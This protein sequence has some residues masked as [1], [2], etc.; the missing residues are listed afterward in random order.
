M[1]KEAFKNAK[2]A[3]KSREQVAPDF[4][5]SK[6]QP[7]QRFDY[8]ASE[9]DERLPD[10]NTELTIK[11]LDALGTAMVADSE[12]DLAEGDADFP[13]VYTYWGQFI[14]HDISKNTDS[15]Q[16]HGDGQAT[17]FDIRPDDFKP[18]KTSEVRDSLLNIRTRHLDLD[19]VYG[20]LDSAESDALYQGADPARHCHLGKKGEF[21]LGLAKDVPG[22]I[23]GPDPQDLCRDL[24]REAP[25]QPSLQ[26]QPAIIAEQRNDENLIVAQFHTAFLRFHNRALAEL[27]DFKRAQK[28]TR[29]HY[30]WLVLHDFLRTVAKPQVVEAVLDGDTRFEFDGGYMPLEFS[31][32][33][34]RFGHSMVRSSYD[35]NHSFGRGAGQL[36]RATF[37]LMFLF[38]GHGG[39]TPLDSDGRL[40]SNWIADWSRLA[41]RGGKFGDGLPE[42]FSRKIDTRLSDPLG[43]LANEANEEAD[44]DGSPFNA[45]LRALM[46]HLARRNLR[47][48]YLLN[49][50][51]G[52]AM[53]KRAGIQELSAEQ[54]LSD[55]MGERPDLSAALQAEDGLLLKYTPLWFYILKEAEVLE[56]GNR[57]G[58]L[59]SRLVVE[60]IVGLLRN[61]EQSVLS[62]NWTPEQSEL[63]T[64]A[65]LTTIDAFLQYSGELEHR[66]EPQSAAMA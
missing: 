50:P 49:I 41:H 63:E 8:L 6:G 48:G 51:T 47:R 42:R 1:E 15:N 3:H 66:P 59:G 53:A 62:L 39:D 36:D 28:Q 33:A 52:Q 57:L 34:Y 4:Y 16:F 10:D 18:V 11:L 38:T 45:D 21:L 24:P 64:G 65:D 32:A 5:S 58:P 56:S 61:S 54:L 9:H 31:T 55:A 37:D 43:Q 20:D 2:G 7:V 26:I 17:L 12:D 19:S 25:E 30:Q 35:F 46:K 44:V 14:D 22:E 23:P 13:P 29:L 40:P 60:T 27:G